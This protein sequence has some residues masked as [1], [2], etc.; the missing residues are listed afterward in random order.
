MR[1]LDYLLSK[2]IMTT[3]ENYREKFVSLNDEQLIESFNREVGN[4][5]WTSS[6]ASFLSALREELQSRFDCSAIIDG[7]MSLR[8][9]VKLVDKKIVVDKK[10]NEETEIVFVPNFKDETEKVSEEG[11][12]CNC[13]DSICTKCL[14]VNCEDDNCEVHPIDKK[15]DFREKYKHR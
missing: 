8:G 15:I 5:G 7:G 1:L 13:D 3:Q 12:K 2:I 14:L 4:S 10:E 6:R 11:K 9:K